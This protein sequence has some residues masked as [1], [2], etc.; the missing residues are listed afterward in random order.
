[1]FVS[2]SLNGF[3][4]VCVFSCHFSKVCFSYHVAVLAPLK[5]LLLYVDGTSLDYTVFQGVLSPSV[6]FVSGMQKQLTEDLGMKMGM[7]SAHQ[8]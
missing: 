4:A 8:R 1:M 2:V 7:S 6:H 3:S 5:F